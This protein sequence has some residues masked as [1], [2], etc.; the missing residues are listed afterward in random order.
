M[1]NCLDIK[2]N[3]QKEGEKKDKIKITFEIIISYFTF[4]LCCSRQQTT[5]C[6]HTNPALNVIQFRFV[7]TRTNKKCKL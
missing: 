5:L 1:H 2:Q 4:E 7:L 6:T 3:K